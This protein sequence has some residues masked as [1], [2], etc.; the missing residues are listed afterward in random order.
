MDVKTQEGSSLSES[1]NITKG[2]TR[3]KLHSAAPKMQQRTDCIEE[4]EDSVTTYGANVEAHFHL[5]WRAIGKYMLTTAH[6]CMS[7]CLLL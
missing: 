5:E 7:L 6:K 3:W 4:E 2:Q 1:G